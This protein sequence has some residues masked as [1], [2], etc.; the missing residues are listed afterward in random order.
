MINLTRLTS[1]FSFALGLAAITVLTGCAATKH[2]QVVLGPKYKPTNVHRLASFIPPVIR[3]VAVLPI[4]AGVEDWQGEIDRVNLQG[5]LQTQLGKA[6]RFELVAVPSAQLRAWTGRPTWRSDDL[7]P[8]D[9][10]KRL[11]ETYDCDAAL[12]VHLGSYHPYKPIVMGWN[13][14]L[15]EATGHYVLWSVDETFDSNDA[16][17]SNAAQYYFLTHTPG[18]HADPERS[19]VLLSPRLFAEYTLSAVFGTLPAR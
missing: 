3:R 4:S 14:K 9:F 13:M 2:P 1:I 11:K 5:V 6:K 19:A 17:V 18:E 15:I 8:P 7:L 12:F 10:M 16:S